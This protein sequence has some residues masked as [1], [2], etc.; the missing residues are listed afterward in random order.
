MYK[1][2][3][4]KRIQD[5]TKD[6]LTTVKAKILTGIVWSKVVSGIIL[7]VWIFYF[8]Y[9]WSNQ[10]LL[11]EDGWYAGWMGTWAD[12]AVHLTYM[13]A[14]AF[15]DSF[16]WELPVFS[17]Q[18]FTY[19]FAADM[20]AGLTVKLG[21]LSMFESYF[22]WGLLLTLLIVIVGFRTLV[23]FFGTKGKPVV[24]LSLWFLGGGLG[25][26]YLLEDVRA[27]G[28]WQAL[29]TLPR[30]YTHQGEHTIEWINLISSIILPQRAF[31]LGAV[32]GLLLLAFFWRI[33]LSKRV[34]W[35]QALVIGL[36]M[37]VLPVVHPHTL[38]VMTAFFIWVFITSF[39]FTQIKKWLA[40]I[41]LA[42]VVGLPLLMTF[43][44]PATSGGFFAW[45]PGWLAKSKH[46]GWIWFWWWNW[47]MLLPSALI[48]LVFT[49]KTLRNFLWPSWFLFALANLFLFQPYDWDNSKILTWVYLLFTI[50]T[51]YFVF[52]LF[53]SRLLGKLL[54]ISLLV[55]LT[56][57]GGL[58]AIRL[59]KTDQN[60][61]LMYSYQDVAL[62][63]EIRRLTPPDSLFL[64]S[65]KHN[66][67]VANLT[68]RQ[69]LMGYRGW[70]WTYGL[71]YRQREADVLAMFAGGDQAMLLFKQYGVDYVTLGYE[72]I[73]T[74]KA[75]RD[76][77]ALFPVVA[78]NDNYTVYKVN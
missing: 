1:H 21:L 13:S 67:F 7:A 68:G 59:L 66:H 25:G 47:G 56:F 9:L 57:S 32:I 31:L 73:N 33:Y 43:V 72:E 34:S 15:R 48:G 16:P 65:D 45:Y 17:G 54:A 19:S 24:A 37:G 51:I 70:L 75:N 39:R 42:A 44:L 35:S 60:L 76:F 8:V 64:T 40:L 4:N 41:S 69:I 14:F 6:R 22:V 49:P 20:L 62:A 12:G 18:P 26:F 53:S 2:A 77:F 74:F 10:L 61:V 3:T 28:F 29:A 36:L 38:M 30:Q 78:K 27:L 55:V 11:G 63:E 46:V 71:D 23:L 52:K 5:N 50:P 58:D